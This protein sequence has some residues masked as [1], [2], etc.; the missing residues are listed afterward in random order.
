[1]KLLVLAIAIVDDIIAISVIAI[2]YSDHVD[3]VWLAVALALVA[4]IVGLK[5]PGVARVAVYIPA[6]MALW[7][8]TL[9]SGVHATVAGVLLGLL[10]PAGLVRG[11]PLLDQLEHR[12]HPY[13]SFLV[14][15]LFALAN[16]GV[17]LGDGALSAR[18]RAA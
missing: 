17:Y 2:F 6:G 1:M 9:E 4:A 7:A 10:T 18:A 16:A 15:P 5:L 14:I 11:R 3:L 12:L 8:A 13:T